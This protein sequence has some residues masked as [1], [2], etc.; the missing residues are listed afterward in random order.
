[1][2]IYAALRSKE[3][4][5]FG[6]LAMTLVQSR[7][8]KQYEPQVFAVTTA[9]LDH[10]HKP[11][12]DCIDKWVSAH[13]IA[14]ESGI[15]TSAFSCIRGYIAFYFYAGLR[16][17]P[18]EN[19]LRAYCRQMTEYG[20]ALICELNLTLFAGCVEADGQGRDCY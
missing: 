6:R 13:R 15:V 9:F 5:R 4:F 19:D 3:G 20:S 11:L 2:I 18:L 17:E 14:M 8:N 10:W 7:G 16:I 1:M 12:Q